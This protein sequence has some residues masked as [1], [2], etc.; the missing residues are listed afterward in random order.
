MNKPKWDETE[1][2]TAGPSWDDTDEI[3]QT[4][5]L[6]S[7]LRGA[8]QGVSFGFAD[9]ATGTLESLF[10]D[11]SYQ[12]AR[13]ESRKAYEAAQKANPNT[14]LA[15]DIG[16]SI[17]TAFIPGLGALNAGK[18][19]KLAEVAAKGALQG[20]L[21]GLGRSEG[22]AGKQLQD[23]A[24]GAILGGATG[25]IASKAGDLLGKAADSTQDV[26]DRFT[27]RSLGGT[28]GQIQKLGGNA[29]DVAEAAR[30]EGIVTP[31]A[32]SKAIAERADNLLNS[33]DDEMSPIYQQ[34]TNSNM[35][36]GDLLKKID[37][38]IAEYQYKPEMADVVRQL[39]KVKQD[40]AVTGK[41]GF[42]PSELGGMRK[43][44]G[45]DVKDFTTGGD[46]KRAK[47]DL[48][49]ITRE[50][51]MGQIEALSPELRTENEALFRRKQL[52][53]M[54]DK[55][56]DSGASRSAAN[57]EIGLNSWQAGVAGGLVTGGM[58]G[59]SI[60]II[61]RELV[62]RYGDQVAGV[63]LDKIAKGMKSPKFASIFERAAQKGP[64]A[65]IAIHEALQRN[66]EYQAMGE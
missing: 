41:V 38:Q 43:K 32:S 8:A 54:L 1:E 65:V 29:A 9:E 5:M 52:A 42:N 25:A 16:G 6:E 27:I 24:T 63:A 57:N 33:I 23:T 34:T 19:A 37:D 3:P 39:E 64:S 21:G 48:Y 17:A 11:K 56:S 18:G 20:G 59:V 2:I 40:I 58:D 66:P 55:M 51:E 36:T 35:A 46:V 45:N 31:F 44:F 47:K 10:S 30:A 60:G 15:G 7:G 61:G 53:H 12:Q 22:D 62:K 49:G 26:A 4:S 14:Y 50:A 28:K 13:D